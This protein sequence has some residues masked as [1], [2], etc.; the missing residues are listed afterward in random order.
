MDYSTYKKQIRIR[1]KLEMM[2][3]DDVLKIF[4]NTIKY[5]AS[6]WIFD[7]DEMYQIGLIA[8]WKAYDNYIPEYSFSTYFS[9]MLN[10]A[11]LNN[12][13]DYKRAQRI[14]TI[15]LDMGVAIEK[16]G[17]TIDLH[18]IIGVNDVDIDVF[19]QKELISN[20]LKK[21]SPREKGFLLACVNKTAIQRSET[22]L[23][24]HKILDKLRKLFLRET[25][26]YYAI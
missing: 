5:K 6:K 10:Y 2:T 21:L 22:S 3:F 13:R 8:L 18:E 20:I 26:G 4:K 23:S 1:D 14:K 17:N 16:D 7:Q 12:Y 9:K 19:A 24:F 25:R 15:S 11:F